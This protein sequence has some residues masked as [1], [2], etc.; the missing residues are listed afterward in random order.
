MRLSETIFHLMGFENSH[1]TDEVYSHYLELIGKVNALPHYPDGNALESF[2]KEIY[3][4]LSTFKFPL[5][6]EEV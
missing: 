4:Q 1:H 5:T 2:A 3:Q 6:Y